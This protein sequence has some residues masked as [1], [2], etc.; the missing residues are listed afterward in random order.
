MIGNNL[1]L[2]RNFDAGATFSP[3]Q[4]DMAGTLGRLPRD[5]NL[6]A[7]FESQRQA[8]DDP[9]HWTSED[10][11]KLIREKSVVYPEWRQ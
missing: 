10:S 5:L 8:V 11:N 7:V 4:E 6:G 1:N 9:R 3:E 2:H